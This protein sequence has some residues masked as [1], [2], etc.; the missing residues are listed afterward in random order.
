MGIVLWI[1]IVLVSLFFLFTGSI[2]VL[3]QPKKLFDYQFETYFKKFGIA[4]AQVRFIGL[5]E[6]IGAIL[7]YFSQNPITGLLGPLLLMFVTVGAIFFHLRHGV[8]QDA[9][10]ALVMFV[11]SAL[12]MVLRLF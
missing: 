12:I 7:L 6:L 10:P 4:R 3:Q 9:M 8:L 1:L 11:L 5:A 2:K